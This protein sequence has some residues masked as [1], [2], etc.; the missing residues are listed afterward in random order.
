M[1]LSAESRVTGWLLISG[2][3]TFTDSRVLEAPNAFDPALIPGERLFRRP[4]HAGNIFFAVNAGKFSGSFAGYFVG[5][6]TDSDFLGLGMTRNA[7][8]AKFDLAGSYAVTRWATA[9]ARVDN[10]FDKQFQENIGYLAY[11]RMFRAGMRFTIG[12][13]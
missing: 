3:Y 9:F 11:G 6:R 1:N 7:G 12:G 13:E 2:A 5:P 8:Y 4:V 10:L